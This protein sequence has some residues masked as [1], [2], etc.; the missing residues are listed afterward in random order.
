MNFQ[1]PA[2]PDLYIVNRCLFTAY[3]HTW[4]SPPWHLLGS[5]LNLP[6]LSWAWLLWSKS[7]WEGDPGVRTPSTSGGSR[8]GHSPTATLEET[9]PK[10]WPQ[11]CRWFAAHTWWSHTEKNSQYE[12]NIV[13]TTEEFSGL[14]YRPGE[15]PLRMHSHIDEKRAEDEKVCAI[16]DCILNQGRLDLSSNGESSRAGIWLHEWQKEP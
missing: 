7:W 4:L 15:V 13:M 16:V 14:V 12:Q 2:H 8:P 5:P 1:R 10:C 9:D 6:S 3:K 11:W